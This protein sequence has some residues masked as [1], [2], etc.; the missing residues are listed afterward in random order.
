[1]G[2]RR[3][4]ETRDVQQ[5]VDD[6]RQPLRL[7]GDE[8]EERSPLHIAE[9]NILAQQRLCEAVDRGQRGAQLDRDSRNEVGF[10]LLDDVLGRDVA[11]RKD[12][13]RHSAGWIA[14]HRFRQ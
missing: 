7:P 10:H 3:T 13:A 5:R 9:G 1:V 12:P 6:R 2:T 11:E 4:V 8:L 14:H